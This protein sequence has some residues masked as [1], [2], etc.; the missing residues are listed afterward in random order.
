MGR[1]DIEFRNVPA[2]DREAE[3]MCRMVL[4]VWSGLYDVG[5]KVIRF[6]AKRVAARMA[7]EVAAH[8]S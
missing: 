3:S 1:S 8:V 7:A 4:G 6:V 2:S 5:L